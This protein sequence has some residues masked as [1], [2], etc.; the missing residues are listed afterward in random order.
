M[1]TTV[2]NIVDD[3]SECRGFRKIS[4]SLS[5]W[6]LGQSIDSA[7]AIALIMWAITDTVV[8]DRPGVNEEDGPER[9]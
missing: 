4:I 8:L 7:I 2:W 1:N 6:L 5:L 9:C 3:K